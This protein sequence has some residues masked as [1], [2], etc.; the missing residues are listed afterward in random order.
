[1][2]YEKSGDWTYSFFFA[3]DF[4]G[5]FPFGTSPLGI[6]EETAIFFGG[7]CWIANTSDG[8]DHYLDGPWS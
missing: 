3:V 1:M 8:D 4:F 5:L 7:G 2:E 6:G